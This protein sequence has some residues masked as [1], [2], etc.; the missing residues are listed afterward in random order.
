MDLHVSLGVSMKCELRLVVVSGFA[1]RKQQLLVVKLMPRPES[2][3]LPLE[4]KALVY[5]KNSKYKVEDERVK[6][7]GRYYFRPTTNL[8]S[9]KELILC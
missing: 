2:M 9:P 7:C 6:G 5:E 1:L 3:A 4:L 8:Q